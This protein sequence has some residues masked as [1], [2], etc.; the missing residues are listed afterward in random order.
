MPVL[1][2]SLLS[3]WLAEHQGGY[4]G[5][6]AMPSWHFGPCPGPCIFWEGQ[7]LSKVRVLLEVPFAWHFW[8]S[9]LC[10]ASDF[11]LSPTLQPSP[12]TPGF[13]IIDTV[14]GSAMPSVARLMAGVPNLSSS[15]HS[16]FSRACYPP[17]SWPQ[18]PLTQDMK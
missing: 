17:S 9:G 16:L 12:P 5:T 10:L 11:F 14:L 7:P 13:S 6:L 8:G 4:C 1:P 2:C 3:W 18:S 15:L